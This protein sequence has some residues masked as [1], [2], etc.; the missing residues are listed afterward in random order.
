MSVLDVFHL[1][2]QICVP[3]TL[4]CCPRKLC[5]LYQQNFHGL[6]ALWDLASGDLKQEMGG[7]SKFRVFIPLGSS[8]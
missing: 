2:L 1:P 3:F 8:L 6:W 7:R 4:L 5:E